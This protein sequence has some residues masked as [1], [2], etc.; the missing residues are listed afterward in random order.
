[1][2]KGGFIS[3]R[4]STP[5][6]KPSGSFSKAGANVKESRL[7]AGGDRAFRG[8]RGGVG[9]KKGGKGY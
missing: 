5:G 4:H 6:G 1:M 7:N 8:K 2:A 9:K 3:T